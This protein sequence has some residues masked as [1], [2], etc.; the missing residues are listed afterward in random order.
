MDKYDRIYLMR[1]IR[2]AMELLEEI[3]TMVEDIETPDEDE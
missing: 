3:K 2:E 1:K